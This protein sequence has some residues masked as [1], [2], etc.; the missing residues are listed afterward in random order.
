MDYKESLSVSLDALRANKMR[1]AL[2]TLG[3]IIGVATI[4]GMMSIVQGLQNYMVS[5]L[6]VLGSNTFQ[7]QK[8]P[9]IQ[10]GH[11]D[12]KY[13]N[14]KILTLEQALAIKKYATL[15]K[16]VGPE[17][18]NWGQVIKY[19]DKK[20]NPDV[21]TAGVTPEFQAANN[22]FTEEGRFINEIDV[23]FN[24]QVTVLGLDIVETLFPHS[25]PM[26]K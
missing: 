18:W 23:Q 25:N 17:T 24:R 22:Y 5:E 10:M 15:V 16:A 14:R 6:S 8:N 7:V 11:L 26:G 12:E 3:I 13:R 9:P 20:T 21:V 4:I 2:T 19:K 1:S